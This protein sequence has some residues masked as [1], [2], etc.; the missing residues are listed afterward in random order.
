MELATR[1]TQAE[2]ESTNSNE[3]DV[4]VFEIRDDSGAETEIKH[5]VLKK[6]L[7][8]DAVEE[9][10][11]SPKNTTSGSQKP[12]GGIVECGVDKTGRNYCRTAEGWYEY[13]CE[14]GEIMYFR[15]VPYADEEVCA[16]GSVA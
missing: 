1:E 9:S 11:H 6:G 10:S 16:D 4:S 14:T 13:R 15:Q 2:A 5:I 8:D 7:L 3:D 12:L